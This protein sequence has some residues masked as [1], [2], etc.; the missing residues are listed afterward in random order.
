M[1]RWIRELPVGPS[2][3]ANVY[4]CEQPC[5]LGFQSRHAWCMPM[6]IARPC[7]RNAPLPA[8]YPPPPPLC[9]DGHTFE[10]HMRVRAAAVL[11]ASDATTLVVGGGPCRCGC[12]ACLATALP[13]AV[14]MVVSTQGGVVGHQV[15][16]KTT[17][18]P[19]S[20]Y[21]TCCSNRH[22][23]G[24][25]T[26]LKSPTVP[27]APYLQPVLFSTPNER[28]WG[29]RGRWVCWTSLPDCLLPPWKLAGRVHG[30]V[31]IPSLFTFRV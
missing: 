6:P 1:R 20:A 11:C 7:S 24:I 25:V 31:S 12:L 3:T 9:A 10:R 29:C 5:C 28:T 27:Y 14:G 30:N 8:I 26:L 21:P 19:L 18:L 15:L 17:A 22:K 16:P 13:C 23:C 4:G 2:S